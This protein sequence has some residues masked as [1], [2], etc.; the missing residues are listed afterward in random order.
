MTRKGNENKKAGWQFSTLESDTA[1]NWTLEFILFQFISSIS[2]CSLQGIFYIF[3]LQLQFHHLYCVYHFILCICVWAII[4][5]SQCLALDKH[6]KLITYISWNKAANVSS[7]LSLLGLSPT[8]LAAVC[9]RAWL[10]CPVGV[11]RPGEWGRGTH[12]A[13][14]T[15]ISHFN[16]NKHAWK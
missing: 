15:W 6:S 10:R 11:R 7:L 13:Y 5:E 16:P 12:I 9:W 3:T 2:I 8:C 1:D 14:C 4:Y